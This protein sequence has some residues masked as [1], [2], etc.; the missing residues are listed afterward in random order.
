MS[1]YFYLEM[2]TEGQRSPFTLALVWL[3]NP[4]WSLPAPTPVP[5]PS[6]C[7]SR[8][9]QSVGS[10]LVG[11]LVPQLPSPGPPGRVCFC[12]LPPLPQA[13]HHVQLAGE[14]GLCGG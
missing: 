13:G 5:C 10:G 6:G 7:H 11:W 4:A 1:L 12:A 3:R 2:D 14:R 9:M 8:D